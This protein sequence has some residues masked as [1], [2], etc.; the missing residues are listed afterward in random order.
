MINRLKIKYQQEILPK[1]QQEYALK[2][3]LA[4]PKLEKIIISI[5]LGEAK[6]NQ[7]VLEIVKKYLSSIAGQMPVVTLAKKSISSFKVSAGQPIGMKLTLRGE[8]MYAFFDRLVNMAL[9]KVRDFKGISVKSFDGRGNLSIG[10][11][12]QT[13]FQEVDYKT[14]D[15]IRG[16]EITIVTTAQNNDQAKMLLELLGMPFRK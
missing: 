7:A 9:P 13:I 6:D 4:I 3:K 10:I 2:N 11:R 14:I 15:K 12:E 1:I 5:G 16:L 8:R